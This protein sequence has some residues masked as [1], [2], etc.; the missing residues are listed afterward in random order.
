ML[1]NLQ[2]G[3]LTFFQLKTRILASEEHSCARSQ[4]IGEQYLALDRRVSVAEAFNRVDN[5][6]VNDVKEVIDTYFYDVDPV[7]V[8]H[9]NLEEMPDYVVM[10]NWTYWNRW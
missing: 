9:G 4:H 1:S 7:V 6:T 10:R 3:M 5:I 8:A 2:E